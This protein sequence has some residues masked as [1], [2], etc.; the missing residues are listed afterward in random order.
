MAELEALCAHELFGMDVLVEVH[1]AEELEAAL[2]L[3]TA[4]LG[5]NNCN[6][7]TFEV[8]LDTTLQL[9]PHI[10]KEQI[11]RDRIGHLRAK[12]WRLWPAAKRTCFLVGETSLC[13]LLNPA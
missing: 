13:G 9:L 3:K 1:N 6:L 12:T 10:S 5:I 4:L 2:K 11:G 8:S 7:R